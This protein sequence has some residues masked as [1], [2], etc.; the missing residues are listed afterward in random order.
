LGIALGLVNAYLKR[1]AK[2]GLIKIKQAPSSRYSYYLTPK[3]F[4]EK[5]RLTATYLSQSMSFFRLVH[6][7]SA[8]FLVYFTEPV[9]RCRYSSWPEIK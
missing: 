7:E 3:G 2:A 9:C 4:V 6:F 1:C 8:D 5:S